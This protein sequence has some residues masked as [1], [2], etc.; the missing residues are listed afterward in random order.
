MKSLAVARDLRPFFVVHPNC[1]EDLDPLPSIS[2]D[3][4]C[5]VLGDAADGF[6]FETLNRAFRI[7]MKNEGNQLFS[8]G[9]GKYYQEDGELTLDVGAFAAA[10]EYSSERKAVVC[11]KP[12]ADFFNSALQDM[13][14]SPSEAIMVG[15]DVVSDVGGA[16][17]CGMQGVLVRTGKF[18]PRD[19]SHPQVTPNAIVNNLAEIAKRLVESRK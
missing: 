9:K 11:G 7:L 2:D 3:F 16:Q 4:N 15:D 17:K 5:V 18:R 13:G 14:L 6:T 8:L 10:L 12:S 19:E 1:L